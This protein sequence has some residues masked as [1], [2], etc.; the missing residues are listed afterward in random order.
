MKIRKA[1]NIIKYL[2]SRVIYFY[3]IKTS[4][5]NQTGSSHDICIC[6]N[7]IYYFYEFVQFFYDFSFSL[8]TGRLF[9]LIAQKTYPANK[10]PYDMKKS[11]FR[12]SKHVRDR[13]YDIIVR[14]CWCIRCIA[15]YSRDKNVETA[16][17]RKWSQRYTGPVTKFS[18]TTSGLIF[19]EFIPLD[20]GDKNC[21]RRSLSAPIVRILLACSH[22][23]P[24]QSPRPRA[25]VFSNI[26]DNIKE[27]FAT[28]YS[29]E[30]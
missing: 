1:S 11:G 2:T 22:S 17:A 6:L 14:R 18:K 7:C 10:I 28:Y 3:F 25:R 4:I 23:L 30:R 26:L 8:L 19:N 5:I 9:L 20:C 24:P 29:K 15:F 16:N 13:A 12:Y 27:A 21:K